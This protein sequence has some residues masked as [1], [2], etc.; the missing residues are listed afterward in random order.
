MDKEGATRQVAAITQALEDVTKDL[1]LY[2]SLVEDGSIVGKDLESIGKVSQSYTKLMV[3][4]RSLNRAARG[5]V[6]SVLEHVEAMTYTG[7]VRAL[8]EIGLF[9]ALP[10]DGTG[11]PAEVLA[12]KL[13][14][15]KELLTRL[16]RAV[17]PVIFAEPSPQ[18]YAHTPYSMV[19]LVPGIRALFKL[20]NG[21][22]GEYPTILIQLSN[23]FKAEGWKSPVSQTNNP[24]TFVHRLNGL[25][26][27]EHVKLDPDYFS[28]F[29]EA[30]TMEAVVTWFTIGI[31][32]FAEKFSKLETTDNTV[33]VVDVGG[34][35]GH[36]TKHIKELVGDEDLVGIEKMN[37]DFFTPNPVKGASIY[38]IRRCLHDWPDAMCVDILKNISCSMAPT[39]RLLIA[40]SVLPSTGVDVQGAWLDILMLTFSGKARTE[41]Q[42]V[43][44]LEASGLRLSKTYILSGTHYG[45]VE[46]YLK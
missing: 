4:V 27:W 39:S 44:L 12:E 10:P 30:M 37:H 33:L 41:Q 20:Q 22:D 43:E 1:K 14:V 42:W 3:S 15:E 40:E 31:Y 28:C 13:N 9:E 18:V 24:Y 8:L 2:S 46:A 6:N 34:G 45:V 21:P 38:Y 11:L 7:V 36:A 29:N 19:Y 17:V 32:P 5:P 23:F 35:L 26:M 25:T 16:M